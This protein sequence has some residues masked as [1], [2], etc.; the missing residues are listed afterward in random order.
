M[1]GSVKVQEAHLVRQAVVYLR[2][3]SAR[4][5]EKNR[6]SAINQ[7]ALQGRLLELGW[8]KSQITVIDDDQGRSGSE[9]AGRE[10]FQRLVADVGL[11]KV[12]ILMG[13][14]VSRLSRNCAD[15][16]RLLELCGLFDTLIAD[17]DGVYQPRDFNDRLLLGLKGTMSEAELHSLR[18]RLDAGRLSKAR[19]GELIQHLPTGYVR[20]LDGTVQRDPDQSIQDRIRLVFRKFFEL[21]SASKVVRYFVRHQLLVPRRQ[22]SGPHTGEIEWK[23]PCLCAL[24]SIL[25]NPAYAGAFAYGRRLADPTQRVPGHPGTGRQHQPPARWLAL[26]KNVYPAYIDWSEYERIQ[27]TIAKNWRLMQERVSRKQGRH[28]VAPLLKG[29]VRCGHCGHAM[30]VAYKGRGI[31]YVCRAAQAKNARPSCQF[32]SGRA[33]DEAVTQEFFRVLQ[34][35]QI[36]AL[37]QVNTRQTEHQRE[38][39]R[40]LEQDVT[41]LEYAAL[42][43]ERQ[44]NHVDPENRL[45]AATLEQKW[46]HALTDL[47][48]ARTRRRD[49]Q[50]VVPQAI[51]VPHELRAAFADVGRQLPQV[52][53]RLSIEAQR[54]LLRTLIT[55]VNLRRDHEGL[56]QV[57]VVWRGG[58]V[59][60]HQVRVPMSSFRFS[61]REQQIVGRVRELIDDGLNDAAIAQ[62]LAQENYHPCRGGRFTPK[63]VLKLRIRHKLL[64]PLARIRQGDLPEGYTI[65]ELAPLIGVDSSWFYHRISKGALLLQKANRFGHY[66]FPRTPRTIQQLQQLKTGKLQQL[67]FPSEH[68]DG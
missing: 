29:L 66:L 68:H 30:S 28:A 13:Y 53:P 12:G 16:H 33:I 45:I 46:E 7:R 6:E 59:S 23:Q 43:A 50:A 9:S 63:I 11:R 27:E 22:R 52:W 35:A 51:T 65:R 4:Q 5:V 25:K 55:G 17:A 31:Q 20:Q 36:D 56:V 3:S 2:Q 19:R 47:E 38:L 10:G 37:E 58:F 61:Q 62:Q 54:Q 32:L 39:L 44:Y 64:S 67:S 49:A 15:W 41:R 40:H 24:R 21:G 34:P 57:R 60:E 1:N 48:H 18:L 14:E 42:R 26:V 8:K